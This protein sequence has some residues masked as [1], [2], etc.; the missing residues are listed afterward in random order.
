MGRRHLRRWTWSIFLSVLCSGCIMYVPDGVNLTARESKV[1]AALP[2]II[3]G[4]TTK[5]EV[6]LTLGE[7]DAILGNQMFYAWRKFKFLFFIAGGY[8]AA[9]TKA[10]KKS[11]LIITFDERGVVSGQKLEED[12]EW[13]RVP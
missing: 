4:Q 3:P 9:G 7:P 12:W 6:V 1:V 5:E 8:S 10:H 11:T 2:T 13:R